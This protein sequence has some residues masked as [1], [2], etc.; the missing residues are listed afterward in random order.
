MIK[1]MIRPS[2]VHRLG[3]IIFGLVR[4]LEYPAMIADVIFNGNFQRIG[5]ESSVMPLFM[6]DQSFEDLGARVQTWDRSIAR[7]NSFGAGGYGRRVQY[8]PHQNAG[9]VR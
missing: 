9:T 5:N 4:A 7:E 6:R 3:R 8:A 2:R 1:S